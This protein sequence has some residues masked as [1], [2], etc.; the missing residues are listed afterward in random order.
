M[1]KNETVVFVVLYPG[2]EKYLDDY[3]ASLQNQTYKEFD[4]YILNDG[5]NNSIFKKYIEKY[6]FLSIDYENLNSGYTPAQIREIG[7]KNIK[8]IY[9]YLIFTDADDYIS[10]DRI[11]KSIVALQEYDFCYNN[12]ILV[13]EEGEKLQEE[14]FFQNKNNPDIV[15]DLQDIIRKNFCGLSNTAV[16]L[17][18]IN[19]DNLIIPRNLIAV[20]WWIYSFLLIKRHKGIYINDALTYY[21]QHNANTVGGQDVMNEDKFKRGLEVKEAHYASLLKY[22]PS[23]YDKDINKQLEQILDLKRN[24]I[25]KEYLSKHICQLNNNGEYMWWENIT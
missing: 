9:S 7:I 10:E 8:N 2:L 3:F 5:M 19:F 24:V 22:Y 25:D 23:K 16:S 21:R 17:K 15:N 20:D 6:N 18:K 14:T 4:L 13:N 1:S 12:M 11:K